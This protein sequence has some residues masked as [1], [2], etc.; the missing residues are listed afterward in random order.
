MGIVQFIAAIYSMSCLA[1]T[2][3]RTMILVGNFGMGLC[4]L[5]IG[6][7]FEFTT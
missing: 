2:R 3:R 5:G 4:A 7:L 6:I 1:K